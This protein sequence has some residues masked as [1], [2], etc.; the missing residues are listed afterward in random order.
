M[1]PI[2]YRGFIVRY[3]LILGLLS[4]PFVVNLAFI[5]RAYE[6]MAF[7]KLVAA[8][9]ERNAVYGTALNQN[10]FGYKLELAAAAR[11]EIVA[12]GSSRVLELREEFFRVPFVNCGGAMNHLNEGRMF[13]DRLFRLH[14]PRVIILGLDFWWFSDEL[15]QPDHYDYHG[16]DG[17][18]LTMEK[19]F[20][21]YL[22]MGEGKLNAREYGRILLWGDRK[23][24][25]TR[26]EGM[27]LRAIQNGDGFRRDGSS[28]YASLIFGMGR[29][30]QRSV[31]FPFVRDPQRAA[32][33]RYEYGDSFSEGRAGELLGILDLCRRHGASVVI[34]MPPVSERIFSHMQQNHDRYRYVHRFERFVA[35]LPLESHNFHDIGAIGSTDCECI[36]SIHI[37]DV[38][39]QRLLLK[40][41][42]QRPDSVL[43]PYLNVPLMKSSV[44][45]FSGKVLTVFE[46]DRERFRL[47]ETSFLDIPCPK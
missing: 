4:L 24:D 30:R 44:A 33:R 3:G 20:K 28:F 22:F 35:D 36:D 11:P 8:Q 42:E 45:G 38:A 31:D 10:T 39:Y 6:N 32:S 37:G 21:P 40:V 16:N 12:L 46:S 5:T 43:K 15:H 23:N 9:R 25:V 17:A 14:V 19:L 29:D 1:K 7:G 13:L 41:L 34:V 47:N 2:G 27:G 26:Y 18:S